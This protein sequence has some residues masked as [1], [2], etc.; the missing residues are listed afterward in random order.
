MRGSFIISFDDFD[1]FG[2]DYLDIVVNSVLK[3]RIY[4]NSS[5]LYSCPL[6]VGD[7][8][9]VRLSDSLP[10][11]ALNYV[12]NRRDYTTDDEG[13][14]NGVKN[15]LVSSGIVSTGFTFTATTLNISYDFEYRTSIISVTPTPTP[16]LTPTITPTFTPTVTPT[17][18]PTHTQ[19]LTPTP[20]LT[21]T[22]TPACFNVG[23]GFS[24]DT[25]NSNVQLAD[26]TLVIVGQFLDY[27]GTTLN[28]IVG[29]NDNGTINTSF[30]YGT[31]FNTDGASAE[32]L[33]S[34]GKIIVGGTFW[35]YRGNTSSKIVRINTD[36]SWDNTYNVG[37]GFTSGG[38]YTN[39][40]VRVTALEVQSNDKV[41]VA[42]FFD[43]YKGV[44]VPGICRLNT[45][46]TLD[47]TFSGIT[48][49]F[50]DIVNDIKVQPDGKILVCGQ[51]TLLD[52]VTRNRIVRLN[53]DGTVDSSFSGVT[54]GF[55]ARAIEMALQPDGKI[56]VG[57]GF[58]QYNGSGTNAS[59]IVRLN[60]NGSRDTSFVIGFGFSSD[61]SALAL[62]SNGSIICGGLFTSF[63]GVTANRIIS[64]TSSGSV[65]T[66][67]VYGT[68]FGTAAGLEVTD[69]DILSDNTILVM[70][71]FF[72]YNGV[73]ENRI[74]R[75]TS[76]GAL[77]NC[78]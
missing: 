7:V 21:P 53:S 5:S 76:T 16:T 74:V 32:K 6:Y 62:R 17:L 18:T 75:L 71:E 43:A 42:G 39:A 54:T 25:T 52:G 46:A 61:V 38:T 29:L 51:F 35:T 24:P 28:G 63:S 27:N 19:T 15:T 11:N 67:F 78:P 22:A 10:S 9:S 26:G 12:L 64:L 31:G 23:T 57:G 69:I 50:D 73:P 40:T 41:I 77:L 8:V 14:D 3:K 4:T 1:G 49:G 70:G 30:V 34:D 2:G 20:T 13:G 33:Q 48:T 66:S 55:N 72:E 59:R 36:G 56:I 37:T 68:G 45:D 44:S 65:D 60:S 47:T 58:S